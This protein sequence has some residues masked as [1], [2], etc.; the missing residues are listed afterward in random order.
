MT[1]KEITTDQ[2]WSEAIALRNIY[3]WTNPGTVAEARS[4]YERSRQDRNDVRF[5]GQ[6]G[7]EIVSYGNA[8]FNRNANDGTYWFG[9]FLDPHASS[10][11]D[12]FTQTTNDCVRRI[13]DFGGTRAMIESRGEYKWEKTALEELG[14]ELDMKLPFSCVESAD[15]GFVLHPNVVSFRDFLDE[16]PDEGLHQ[17]WRLEMDVASDLPLPFPFVETPFEGYSKFILDPEVDLESKFLFVEDGEL[18]GLSQ[19]WPSKVNPKLASTG[20]T[21]VRRQYRRQGVATK[22]KQHAIAW[23]ASK[24]IEKIFT[25]NEEN[26]PMYQLN[27]QLGFRHMFNY[28]VYSKA[29]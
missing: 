24:G 12:S 7:D 27:L 23:A 6:I 26:N 8:M 17:I 20:L 16:N 14:F 15:T 21:G 4:F 18:K 10:A 1:F 11:P 9:V 22:T 25:D 2:D 13:Q 28:E 5:V 29:C 3:N 19:L